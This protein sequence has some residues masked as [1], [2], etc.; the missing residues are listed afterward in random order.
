MRLEI[1]EVGDPD[2]DVDPFL[3][4][5]DEAV[6]Q[7]QFDLE[8][9]IKPHEFG[10]R[11]PE[12]ERTERGWA[13]ELEDALRLAVQARDLHFGLVDAGENV[14]AAVVV[15][16][17]RL[18]RPDPPRRA[19]EQSDAEEMLELHHRLARRR[20]GRPEGARRLGKAAER[21]HLGEGVHRA[22]LVHRLYPTERQS[23]LHL[24]YC[25]DVRAAQIVTHPFHHRR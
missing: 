22:E 2:G 24:A 13:V 12:V 18:G 21:H 1:G 15:G 19:V 5:V 3:D 4:R 10:D 17:T 9:E 8:I 16:E 14:D 23:G 20:P 25:L 6:G 7:G 11:R